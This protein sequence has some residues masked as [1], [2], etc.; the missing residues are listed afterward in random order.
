MAPDEGG[1][2]AGV[3]RGF[4]VHGAG[5]VLRKSSGEGLRVGADVSLEEGLRRAAPF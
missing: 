5:E 4:P 2:M 3:V 1:G